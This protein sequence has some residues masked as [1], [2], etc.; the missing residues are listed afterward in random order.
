MTRRKTDTIASLPSEVTNVRH[1]RTRED[2]FST[3]WEQV[4]QQIEENLGLEAKTLFEWLQREYPGRYQDGQIRTLQRRIKPRG[5]SDRHMFEMPISRAVGTYFSLSEL[6][7]MRHSGVMRKS[8]VG[9]L[10][11][12]CPQGLHGICRCCA[13]GRNKTGNQ[14]S[15]AEKKGNYNE[16]QPIRSPHAVEHS[17]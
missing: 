12:F 1:W 7:M 8:D 17:L 14:C 3:V 9:S 16:C 6:A 13:A 5:R 11:S 15:E 2:P 10:W 4:R